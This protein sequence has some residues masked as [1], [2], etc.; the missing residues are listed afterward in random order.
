MLTMPRGNPSPKLAISVPADVAA[1]IR[2]AAAREHISV[3]EWMTNVARHRLQIEQGLAAVAE[4][5]AEHGAFTEEE[6][7]E[8]EAWVDEL[9]RLSR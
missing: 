7:A 9:E 6:L 1:G 3:S 2:E 4:Y 8:A 5:E